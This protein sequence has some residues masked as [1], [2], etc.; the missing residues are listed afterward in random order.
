MKCY[1]SRS[2]LCPLDCC[3]GASFCFIPYSFLF[4]STSFSAVQP[5]SHS[6]SLS[7]VELVSASDDIHRFSAQVMYLVNSE[8]LYLQ[9]DANCF[10][11]Q[12]EH[13]QTAWEL[14]TYQSLQDFKSVSWAFSRN[15][16]SGNETGCLHYI[17]VVIP[18]IRIMSD[19]AWLE[20]SGTT[21][22]S[23]LISL[24]LPQHEQAW[25]QDSE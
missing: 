7:S 9:G 6:S 15:W 21:L 5:H 13:A 24:C 8:H 22:F 10:S 4:Q 3:S 18:L 25:I 19:A 17:I 16:N 23:F 1:L 12:R 20:S 2:W 11:L 14:S